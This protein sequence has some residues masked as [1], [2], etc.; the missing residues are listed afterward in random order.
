M[1]RHRTTRGRTA[2][3]P[4][5]ASKRAR[6]THRLPGGRVSTV[7]RIAV[8]AVA[9]GAIV[10]TAALH[11]APGVVEVGVSPLANG[12]DLAAVFAPHRD[13]TSAAPQP[14][15]TTRPADPAAE[16]GKLAKA[17]QLTADSLAK[18]AEEKAAADKTAADKAAADKAAAELA[19]RAK[20]VKPTEGTFTSGFGSRWGSMH[21]G[22]DLA[23]AIGTPIVSVADG[24]VVEAGPASGFGL[25][26]RVQHNDGTITVYGH[27]NETLVQQGQQVRAGQEIA[28]LG[29]RGESTG[30]HL[31][32]EVWLHGSAAEKIDPLPWLAERGVAIS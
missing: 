19:A 3:T 1:A 23:N 8:A 11:T 26:V 21:Y 25:W 2:F 12:V 13:A 28:T 10:G 14:I 31:H 16:A 20:V 17:A 30:P 7:G 5:Q 4:T 27:V 6:G 29:N 15:V 18:A 32:F 24:V 22:I 9:A